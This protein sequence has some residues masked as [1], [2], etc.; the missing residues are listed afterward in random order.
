M[1]DNNYAVN[2]KLSDGS[3]AS[4]DHATLIAVAQGVRAHVQG[5]FDRE[6]TLV[7]AIDAA[8][9]IGALA[10]DRHRDGMA[11]LTP[12]VFAA[13]SSRMKGPSS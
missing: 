3:F 11:R 4:F 8:S 12:H 6:A 13:F 2:W 9:D 7:A 1:L 10:G 5:C